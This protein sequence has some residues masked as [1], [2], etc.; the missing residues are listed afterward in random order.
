MDP[1][2]QPMPVQ[3]T[4][5]YTMG[6]IPTDKYGRVV[7]DDL[8][9]V[10]PG[11]YAAGEVACVSVHGANRLGCNSLLDTVVFGRR[12]G[13]AMLK[14]IAGVEMGEITRERVGEVEAGLDRLL[15]GKG[16]EH[17]GQIRSELQS[18]MMEDCSV[19]RS[20]ERLTDLLTNI[21]PL[22][23]RVK[24]IGITDRGRIFNTDLLE[25]LELE[26]LITLG[27]VIAASALQREESRGAHSREDFP[28]R[29]DKNWLKHTLAFRAESVIELRHRPVRITRFQPQER[30]Y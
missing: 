10:L 30:K 4:A 19:F 25:A 22:K 23:E 1:A 13:K 17:P 20:R 9:T 27:E 16:E 26:H 8:N 15:N 28:K 11:L 18:L 2:T 24:E 29:D 7:I 6:G 12:A 14:E 3:P 5:H 21:S